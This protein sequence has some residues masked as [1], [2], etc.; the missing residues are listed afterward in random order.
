MDPEVG[1]SSPPNCTNSF[2][3]GMKKVMLAADCRKATRCRQSE[4]RRSSGPPH[5]SCRGLFAGTNAL[6]RAGLE[7]RPDRRERDGVSRRGLDLR[8]PVRAPAH[9]GA[10]L[11][12]LHPCAA[13]VVNSLL[14]RTF[15]GLVRAHWYHW[16]YGVFVSIRRFRLNKVAARGRCAGSCS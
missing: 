15:H 4:T 2:H 8:R 12:V 1:G 6:T 7:S 3:S 13:V 9:R 10:F 14:T 5:A 16:V 11:C